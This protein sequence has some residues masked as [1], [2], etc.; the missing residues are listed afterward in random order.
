MALEDMIPGLYNTNVQLPL[1][2]GNMYQGAY[3]PM[4]QYLGGQA[5][6]MASLGNNYV[7]QMGSLGTAGMGLYGNL[8]GQQAQM[9]QSELP[10][11]MEMQ[12]FN[13]LA[14]ALSGLL[15]YGGFGGAGISPISMNFN[16]P[17]VMSGYKGAVDTAY[18]G[19]NSGY[20]RAVQNT[21]QYDAPTYGF[22]G[23]MMDKMPYAPFMPHPQRQDGPMHT[24]SRGTAPMLQSAAPQQPPL[25]GANPWSSGPLSGL[26][27][28]RGGR[29]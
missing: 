24:G 5:G 4:F 8:A 13:A 21:S 26:S 9:Y 7:G 10:F 25:P 15:S 29:F 3:S 16:R 18:K 28:R 23:D 6:N 2:Y 17:D 22:F 20:D 19:V 14:P 1:Q 27:S 12:K 11:Q